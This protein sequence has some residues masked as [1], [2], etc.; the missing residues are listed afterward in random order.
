EATNHERHALR[1]CVPK[2]EAI[3]IDDVTPVGGPLGAGG[4]TFAGDLQPRRFTCGAVC[5]DHE[6]YE[7]AKGTCSLAIDELR[8]VGRE[9]RTDVR[10]L[11]PTA[12]HDQR[13]LDALAN[14][15]DIPAALDIRAPNLRIAGLIR[16]CDPAIA[17][18][19]RQRI[20]P[21][22]ACADDHDPD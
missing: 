16:E 9:G 15:V 3:E 6:E 21:Q 17:G 22:Q 20:V 14:E 7:R 18:P 8:A 4:S 12:A 5:G 19:R 1:W 11:V 10:R 13:R 2:R